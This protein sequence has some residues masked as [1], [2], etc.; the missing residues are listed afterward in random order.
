MRKSA[1]KQIDDVSVGTTALVSPA[2]AQNIVVVGG[3][4]GVLT[5]NNTATGGRDF[6]RAGRGQPHKRCSEQPGCAG[7]SRVGIATI[8]QT[9]ADIPAGGINLTTVPTNSVSRLAAA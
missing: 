5:S 2:M 4:A 9:I 8:S 3:G 6:L 1:T 7:D